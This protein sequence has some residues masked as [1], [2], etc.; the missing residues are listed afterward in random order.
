MSILRW[1]IRFQKCLF[2][3]VPRAVK[4]LYS[5]LRRVIDVGHSQ[6]PVVE[7]R[8][9]HNV[10]GIGELKHGHKLLDLELQFV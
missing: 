2:V 9:F 6:D 4:L 1:L 10:T 8:S 5:F 3:M 7:C